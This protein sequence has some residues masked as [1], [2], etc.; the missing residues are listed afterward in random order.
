[1]DEW[2]RLTAERDA[3]RRQLSDLAADLDILD[4][5]LVEQGDVE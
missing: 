5:K 1:L 4:R 3:A 2:E